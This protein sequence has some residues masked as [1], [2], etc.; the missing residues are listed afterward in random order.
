[1]PLCH[2][3][4]WTSSFDVSFDIL[5]FNSLS[6]I[7]SNDIVD[8]TI[9]ERIATLWPLFF[10]GERLLRPRWRLSSGCVYLVRP[11]IGKHRTRPPIWKTINWEKVLPYWR[12][13]RVWLKF[14][15]RVEWHRVR[16]YNIHF[17]DFMRFITRTVHSTKFTPWNTFHEIH[18]KLVCSDTLRIRRIQFGLLMENLHWSSW[19]LHCS[20]CWM[21]RK[22]LDV[23]Q[24]KNAFRSVQIAIFLCAVQ[25]NGD[26]SWFAVILL[27]FPC[28]T[29][30][31]TP[32]RS[33]FGS[34][35]DHVSDC[36]PALLSNHEERAYLTHATEFVQKC[37]VCFFAR[38]LCTPFDGV[39]CVFRF[40]CDWSAET[41]SESLSEVCGDIY[42]FRSR[43]TCGK[44]SELFVFNEFD[45]A[46][47]STLQRQSR[48]WTPE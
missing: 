5:S 19:T 28:V 46:G 13:Q 14:S 33:P 45:C 18:F 15:H 16:S 32:F 6:T 48:V 22:Q 1:M 31:K 36:E 42:D 11:A 38:R 10:F 17:T 3:P 23:L 9:V 21:E 7:P 44:T 24:T 34:I 41:R 47:H 12:I 27:P 26:S 30:E 2:I 4:L 25:S 39:H 29:N 43:K 20:H 37:A 8:Q 35:L 40:C